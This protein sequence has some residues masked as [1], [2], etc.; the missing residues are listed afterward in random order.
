MLNIIHKNVVTD[1]LY[2][3]AGLFIFPGYV[4]CSAYVM[5]TLKHY[6]RLYQSDISSSSHYL[7]IQIYFIS[8]DTRGKRSKIPRAL[9]TSLAIRLFI[10]SSLAVLLFV[11]PLSILDR[12]TAALA[13]SLSPSA[14]STRNASFVCAKSKS[15]SFSDTSCRFLS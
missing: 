9:Y 7:Y 13:S 5:C 8:L 2:K 4:N 10:R 3:R 6:I 14:A 12:L 1:P 11:A 15:F